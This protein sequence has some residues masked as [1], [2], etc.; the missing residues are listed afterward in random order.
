MGFPPGF[1]ASRNIGPTKVTHRKLNL[2]I[3]NPDNLC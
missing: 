1:P 2:A 3:V